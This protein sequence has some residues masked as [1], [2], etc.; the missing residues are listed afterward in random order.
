MI[1]LQTNLDEMRVHEK[2]AKV[3]LGTAEKTQTSVRERA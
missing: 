2:E 3:V 1:D